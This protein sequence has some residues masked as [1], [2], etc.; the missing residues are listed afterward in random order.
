MA[1][2]ESKPRRAS[3]G[4]AVKAPPEAVRRARENAFVATSCSEFVVHAFS[5]IYKEGKDGPVFAIFCQRC[6]EF[7]VLPW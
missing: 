4:L 7:R 6:G 5:A 1:D 3:R 2:A